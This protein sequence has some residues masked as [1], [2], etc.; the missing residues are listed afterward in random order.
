LAQNTKTRKIYQNDLKLNQMSINIPTSTPTRPSKIYPNLD[1]WLE[2]EPSG[3]PGLE[4][5]I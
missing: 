5:E 1:F 3:N 2:N 4:F